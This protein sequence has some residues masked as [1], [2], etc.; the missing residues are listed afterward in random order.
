MNGLLHKIKADRVKVNQAA[1]TSDV[2][3]DSVDMSGFRG[4]MFVVTFGT[5]TASAVTSVKGQQSSD[6]GSSDTFADLTGTSIS[7]ADSDDDKVVLL[8]IYRP[9]ERYLRCVVDR[10]TAN[11]EIDSITAFLYDPVNEPTTQTSDVARSELHVSPVEG[12][13]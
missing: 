7:V 9:N 10:G 3:S 1:G 8:D 11:A 6:D 5:I 13:A 4:V 12:T 2:N